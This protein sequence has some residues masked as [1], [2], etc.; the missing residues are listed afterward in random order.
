MQVDPDGPGSITWE[1][2]LVGGTSNPV[3]IGSAPDA[4]TNIFYPAP[5]S[6]AGTFEYICEVTFSAGGCS[7]ATSSSIIVTIVDNPSLSILLPPDAICEG[8]SIINDLS[9]TPSGGTGTATYTWYEVSPTPGLLY[10][11]PNSFY[12]PGILSPAGIYEYQVEVVYNGNG[13]LPDMSNTVQINVE[14]VNLLAGKLI[15]K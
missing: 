4:T 15:L 7:T 5:T 6:G 2:N 11:G 10:T 14:P 3:A 9:V 12:N 8:G 1:W 13:C